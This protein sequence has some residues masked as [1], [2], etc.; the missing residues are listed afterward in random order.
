MKCFKTALL[1]CA[2][3]A[4]SAIAM[5]QNAQAKLDS[6]MIQGSVSDGV[7]AYKG[8]P[9]AAPPVGP[10]RWRAQPVKPWTGVKQTTAFAPDCMQMASPS[11]PMALGTTPAEDC[12]YANVW[13]PADKGAGRLPVLVWIYGG[14]LVNGGSSPTVYSGEHFARKGVMFV[15]FNYRLGRFGFFGHP[16]LTAEN[17]DG[18]LGNYGFMDEIAALKWVQRNAA[19]FGGD[20]GNVTVL[21]ESAG[22]RSIHMLLGTSLANGLYQRVI[23]NSGGG[24]NPAPPSL[25]GT[26]PMGQPSAEETGL[27]FAKSVGVDGRGT[28]ALA[29]LRALPAETIRGNLSMA[30][31]RT[32]YFSL[33]M[34][35]GKINVAS[36]NEQYL[37]GATAKVPMII[38]TTSADLGS[39]TPDTLDALFEQFGPYA[40]EAK[41]AYLGNGNKDLAQLRGEIGR[42]RAMLE[43]ARHVATTYALRG[44]PTYVFRFSY[45]AASMRDQWKTG[46][47]HA[48]ELPFVFNTVRARYGAA[49]TPADERT[50]DQILTYYANFAKTGDPNGAGLPEWP[51]YDP[52]KDVLMNFT[53]M[54][55][56]WQLKIPSASGW[57]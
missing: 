38:G 50:A 44:I 19:A 4:A 16:A 21:G 40:E 32:N 29:K 15:T 43:P 9:F 53:R 52:A 47:P 25:S 2:L 18:L 28:E 23:I 45:V 55:G 56:R 17:A 46:V 26:M 1:A 11:G 31:T 8:I 41:A 51:K 57:M 7:I 35:D 48:M 22:G 39:A 20:A 34:I 42:D 49:T 33:N 30:T 12:L 54:M 10:L 24:R 14:G 6:G 13:L 27:L 37:A 36:Q 5:A 3:S